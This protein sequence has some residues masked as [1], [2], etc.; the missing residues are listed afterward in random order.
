MNKFYFTLIENTPFVEHGDAQDQGLKRQFSTGFTVG[1]LLICL[2]ENNYGNE[3]LINNSPSIP[4]YSAISLIC[5]QDQR[6]HLTN[7]VAKLIINGEVVGVN[8]IVHP[9]S[10]CKVGIC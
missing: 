10:F 6:V 7:A 9:S 1:T 2:S 5:R 8:G 3:A 4:G